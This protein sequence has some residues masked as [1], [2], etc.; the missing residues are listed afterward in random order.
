MSAG[1]AQIVIQDRKGFGLIVKSN[2]EILLHVLDTRLRT[3]DNLDG[4]GRIR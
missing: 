4:Y 1:L 3:I 2:T